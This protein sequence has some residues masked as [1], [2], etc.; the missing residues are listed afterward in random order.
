MAR[1]RI[2]AV[3]DE[4][5]ALRRIELLLRD[6]PDVEL[7]G[8]A[9]SAEAALPLIAELTPDVLLLD[10]KM[11]PVS[12]L[13]MLD[14]LPDADPPAVVF[15][16]AYDHYAVKAFDLNAVDYVLKP[17]RAERLREALTRARREREIA[18]A[19]AQLSH[20][21]AT[22]EKIGREQAGELVRSAIWAERRGERVRVSLRTINWV[23]AEGDYVRIHLQDGSLLQRKT[24]SSMEKELGPEFMRVHRSSLVRR[25]RVGSIWRAGDRNLRVRLE[26]GEELKVGRSYEDSIR[27]LLSARPD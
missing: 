8:K 16:T 13:E 27:A 17:V 14:S 5:L 24:I 9:R 7:V 21:R 20:L 26:S 1:L 19:G 25:D 3:D 18:A 2:L 22:V 6:W 23:Q 4:L 15:V 10:I 12:G 11:G